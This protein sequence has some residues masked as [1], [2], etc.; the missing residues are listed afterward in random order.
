MTNPKPL[1]LNIFQRLGYAVKGIGLDTVKGYNQALDAYESGESA[2]ATQ[3]LYGLRD[4]E[5]SEKLPEVFL[6]ALALTKT[7]DPKQEVKVDGEVENPLSMLSYVWDRSRGVRNKIKPALYATTMQ[8][9]ER[10]DPAKMYKVG[11]KDESIVS[12]LIYLW[13]SD[14]PEAMPDIVNKTSYL[15]EKLPAND[16]RRFR[17]ARELIRSK[18]TEELKKMYEELDR[19]LLLVEAEVAV[20]ESQLLRQKNK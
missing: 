2:K 18:S 17:E 1:G 20:A 8:V 16:R 14:A 5:G 10:L 7:I 3:K 11:P 15:L 12:L 6:L 4:L 9:A 13:D 19:R